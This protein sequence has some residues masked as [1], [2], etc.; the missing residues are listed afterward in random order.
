ML[1][2]S[3]MSQAAHAVGDHEEHVSR[4][5]PRCWKLQ[6]R[7]QH[8]FDDPVFVAEFLVHRWRLFKSRGVGE[9]KARIDV[10][11]FDLLQSAVSYR[12]ERGFVRS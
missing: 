9:D 6:T 4:A 10:A 5:R 11:G 3:T 8:D 12:L 2:N 1:Q 7:T